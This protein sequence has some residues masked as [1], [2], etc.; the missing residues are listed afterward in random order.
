MTLLGLNTLILGVE[1][2]GGYYLY[3]SFRRLTATPAGA[4]IA[5]AIATVAALA[6]ST[7]LFLGVIYIGS[8]DVA[9]VADVAGWD[10]LLARAGTEEPGFQLFAQAV[11]IVGAIGWVIEGVVT[12]AVVSIR[13]CAWRSASTCPR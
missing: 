3:S 1:T 5:A 11:L 9:A 4:G 13:T 12:G 10:E 6:V 8:V 2:V 7:V